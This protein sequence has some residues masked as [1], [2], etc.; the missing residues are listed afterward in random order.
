M[1]VFPCW[2]L[3]QNELIWN[4]S[5]VFQELPDKTAERFQYTNPPSYIWLLTCL[6][7]WLQLVK[8]FWSNQLQQ[9]LEQVHIWKAWHQHQRLKKDTFR[10]QRPP[11]WSFLAL[12]ILILL[13]RGLRLKTNIKNVK[14]LKSSTFTGGI[15]ASYLVVESSGFGRPWV[16]TQA[17]SFLCNE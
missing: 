10:S 2:N 3:F 12:Y 8:I 17:R 7:A 5:A 9:W 14:E 6:Q 16:S 15:L 11:T 13:S 1:K 4:I